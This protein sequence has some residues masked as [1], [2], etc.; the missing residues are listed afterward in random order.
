MTPNTVRI[1]LVDDEPSHTHFVEFL[2][3]LG[4][5][6]LT[7]MDRQAAVELVASERVDLVLLDIKAPILGNCEICRQIR[8]FSAVPIIILSTCSR[9]LD[10]VKGL[11]VGADDYVT[12]PFNM[13]ELLAR[14]RAVL[15]RA[16]PSSVMGGV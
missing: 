6:I 8:E 11:K 4:Y 10:K 14:M 3:F 13:G 2:E 15:R 16:K 5:E 9:D 7:T 1:L 12:K